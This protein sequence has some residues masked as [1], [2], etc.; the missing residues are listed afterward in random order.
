[1]YRGIPIRS[2]PITLVWSSKA[3]AAGAS[4][5]APPSGASASTGMTV[6]TDAASS[7][8]AVTG[9]PLAAGGE[10]TAARSPKSKSPKSSETGLAGV[11]GGFSSMVWVVAKS[12]RAGSAGA[13]APSARRSNSCV[14]W[15][16]VLAT[17]ASSGRVNIWVDSNSTTGVA[18]GFTKG[19]TGCSTTASTTTG[20]S[21]TAS[22]TTVAGGGTTS[23]VSADCARPGGTRAMRLLSRRSASA[24]VRKAC[25]DHGVS[26]ACAM[27]STH[28]LNCRIA[29]PHTASRSSL[30]GFCSASQVLTSCSSDHAASPNSFRPTMRELPL[31]V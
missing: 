14:D 29:S 28:W 12:T 4:A 11:G 6:S 2:C 27:S 20:C 26:A 1:M 17:G 19:N 30:A 31:R 23:G 24:A 21:T 7:C 10:P 15:N 5:R 18:T 22:S 25:A 9:P 13:D 3:S 16:S 8:T